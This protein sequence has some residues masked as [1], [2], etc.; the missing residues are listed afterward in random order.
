MLDMAVL[1][2]AGA[3]TESFGRSTGGSIDL[4]GSFFQTNY[5]TFRRRSFLCLDQFLG[6]KEAWVLEKYTTDKHQNSSLPKLYLSTNATTFGDIWGPMWKSCEISNGEADENHIL[7]YSVGNGVILPWSR[8]SFNSDHS[9]SNRKDE[10]FCHWIS[11]KDFNDNCYPDLLSG[12]HLFPENMLLIGASL[13]LDYNSQCAM[14]VA[15]CKQGF[16][17]SGALSELGTAKSRRIVESKS[18][19]L[20]VGPPYAK[21]GTQL[22]YKRRGVT[23]KNAFIEEWKNEPE[24]RNVRIL[25]YKFGVEVS[26]CTRNA[27]RR[28]LICLLGSNTMTNYLKN[29]T[30][31]WESPDCENKFYSVLK[32][33]TLNGASFKAFRKLYHSEKAWQ[34]DIGK[35]ITH[36]LVGLTETGTNESGLEL[37][38]VPNKEPGQRVNLRFQE[39]NWA[40]FLK[41]TETVCTMAI[42][43]D[44]CLELPSLTQVNRCHS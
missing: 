21:I 2:Y 44:K 32:E 10:K 41:D 31:T 29:M 38:W 19:L 7:L 30:L 9:S 3:H 22:T 16:R 23:W 35:A 24:R 4:P 20:Q 34:S 11:D 43:E 5:F 18:V 26:T 1:S 39:H 28:R 40:G 36:C 25:E 15:A 42:L 13:K 12:E 14:S 8:S 6:G 37:L 27:R 17:D 33:T